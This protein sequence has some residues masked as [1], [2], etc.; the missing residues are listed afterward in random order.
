MSSSWKSVIRIHSIVLLFVLCVFTGVALSGEKPDVYVQLGLVFSANSVSFSPD[1]RSVLTGGDDQTL[2]LWDVSTGEEIRSFTGHA[3][4]V[5]SVAFSPDGRYALSGSWD[6]TLKL[7][8]VETGKEI[9]TFNG[10]VNLVSSVTFSPDGRYALSGSWDQTLKLWDVETGKEIRTFAG[11]SGSVTSVSFAPDGR[12]ALSGSYDKTAILWHVETGEE[13][14]SFSGHGGYVNAVTFSRDGLYAASASSDKTLKLWDVKTGKEIRTYKGHSNRIN[15]ISFSPDN[16]YIL[17][18]SYDGTLMRWDVTTGKRVRLYSDHSGWISSVSISPDGMYAV[19][20]GNSLKLRDMKNGS[21][22]LTFK[23][24]SNSVKSVVFSTSDRYFLSGD[25]NTAFKLWDVSTGKELA[26]LVSFTNGEWIIIT[27]DGFFDS[28]LNGA[29]NLNLRIGSSV[30]SIDQFIARLYRPDLVQ[31]VLSGEELPGGEEDFIQIT[32]NKAAPAV[33][34]VSPKSG[35]VLDGDS[36]VLSVKLTENDGGIGNINVYCNGSLVANETKSSP[37]AG[38]KNPNIR[39]LTFRVP[40]VSGENAVSVVAFNKDGSMGSRP[41]SIIVTSKAV[42]SKPNLHAIIVG[43]NRYGNEFIS[44]KYAASDAAAFAETLKNST[45]TLF[46]NVNI[47]VLTSFEETSKDAI[48]NAF[49]KIQISIKPN[50]LFVFYI[51][52]HG[53]IDTVDGEENYYLLTSNVLFLSSHQIQKQALSQKEI[54]DLIGNV[55]TQKKFILFD[56]CHAG[57]RTQSTA[58]ESFRHGRGLTESAAV[59]LLQRTIGGTFISS[60][61]DIHTAFEGYQEHGLFSY[62]L[63][64]GLK[65][66]AEVTKEGFIFIETLAEYVQSEMTRLSGDVFKKEQTPILQVGSNFPVAK[67]K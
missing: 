5:S 48:K 35:I 41:A 63:N 2:K 45:G 58:G 23:E 65:G 14:R 59:K 44:L 43:I 62:V 53:L 55:P 15:S 60:S 17:S 8:D 29:K 51:A 10:H 34:I 7:W 30:Y 47:T 18:G 11:H 16:R 52:S 25:A 21:E 4:L 13:L 40:L 28:S 61:S 49:E 27:P 20:G 12:T 56:T 39:M 50:D 19:L 54:V 57:R 38:E 1:G 36:F 31:R 3:S 66:K 42:M 22:I 9:K 32:L 67:I 24:H 37:I 26:M 6:Q 46:G 64:E 33:E